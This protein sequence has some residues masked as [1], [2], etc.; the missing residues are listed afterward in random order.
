MSDLHIVAGDFEYFSDRVAAA[1]DDLSRLDVDTAAG[2]I[3]AGM[4][5]S[6]SAAQGADVSEWLG[7][8]VDALVSEL[9]RFSADVLDALWRARA[10]EEEV[11]S[12]F[13]AVL[14]V[15]VSNAFE[16]LARRLGGQ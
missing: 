4:P 14:G 11:A 5:G 1:G 16:D 12:T 7:Q 3:A 6:V 13:T 8:G 9:G 15:G 2:D 10:A